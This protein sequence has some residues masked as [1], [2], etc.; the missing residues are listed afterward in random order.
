M[1]LVAVK[2][3]FQVVIPQNV[4]K[5]ISIKVGDFMEAKAER[6]SVVLTPKKVIDDYSDMPNADDEYTPAQRKALDKELA[7]ALA[8]VRAGNTVGPFNTHKEMMDYLNRAVK[9]SKKHK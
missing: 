9:K 4:R 3:K 6:G 5:L 2:N 8:D 7:E 1:Q